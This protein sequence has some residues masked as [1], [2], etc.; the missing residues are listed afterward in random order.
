MARIRDCRAGFA[1]PQLVH[2]PCVAGQT[3]YYRS[4]PFHSTR[5]GVLLKVPVAPTILNFTLSIG[6]AALGW[7]EDP[8]GA[9]GLTAW[10]A[11]VLII[12]CTELRISRKTGHDDVQVP[13]NPENL[14]T[15][16]RYH[17]NAKV[18]HSS[19]V[20]RCVGFGVATGGLP[21]LRP[22]L[23]IFRP[24]VTSRCF[25]SPGRTIADSLPPTAG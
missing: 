1:R 23:K 3:C 25:G 15:P 7:P 12:L 11:L 21:L 19:L 16:M 14:S 4:V 20:P 8:Q 13:T 2:D 9:Y 22:G 24:I 17:A 10:L 6:R 18:W 5:V